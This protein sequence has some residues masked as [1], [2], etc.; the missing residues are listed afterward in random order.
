MEN[1]RSV[2][3]PG[4]ITPPALYEKALIYIPIHALFMPLLNQGQLAW[5]RTH[6]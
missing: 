1:L 6:L 5:Y 2:L 3:R 4:L